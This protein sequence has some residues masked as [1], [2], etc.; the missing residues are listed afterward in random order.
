MYSLSLISCMPFKEY[1][2]VDH[3]L[4]YVLYKNVNHQEQYRQPARCFIFKVF[5]NVYFNE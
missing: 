2:N 3:E 1:N 5:G 4:I